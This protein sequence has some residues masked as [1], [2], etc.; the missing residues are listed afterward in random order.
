M[1]GWLQLTVNTTRMS[2]KRA[3]LQVVAGVTQELLRYCAEAD[4]AGHDPY[5]ALNSRLFQALPFR[6]SK[7][8]RLVFTQAMKRS[9]LNCRHL[10]LVPRT[11]NP[12][13]LA[14]FLTSL[15]KL[16]RVGILQDRKP[17][18]HLAELLLGFRTENSGLSCWGYSFD[19]QTRSKLVPR[20]S[21]NIICTTFAANAL[22]DA[23]EALG[24]TEYRDA[25]IEAARFVR[26]HLY[27][28]RG[29]IG[30]FNYTPLEDLQIHN[31]NLLGAALLCRAASIAGDERFITP[32]LRATRFSTTRQNEDGS[33]YYGERSQPSQ[34][35]IDNFHTG[36]NLC[37]LRRVCRYASTDEFEPSLKRGLEY[38]IN[39]FF[40]AGNAPKYFHN[41]TYPI[42][43]HSVAQSIVTL[44]ELADMRP[45]AS[46]LALAVFAWAHSNLWDKRGYFYYQKHRYWTNRIPYMRWSQAWMLLALASLMDKD[47][48]SC[49]SLKP[50]E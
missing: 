39:H 6:H 11:H 30:W 17:L 19:W 45:G 28:E 26:D 29:D 34:K 13:G 12:K 40:A 48:V 38:Y 20:G 42:D 14:L 21:A 41:Q 8:A 32:A 46:D 36:F 43:V 10:L 5:D 4:W 2:S 50:I 25:G 37:A 9:A 7:W 33:W 22:I 15:V 3:D 16:L 44:V 23:Y 49:T 24:V 27:T 35:W 1:S 47:V 18:T 31:A